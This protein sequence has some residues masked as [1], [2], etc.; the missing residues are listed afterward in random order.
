MV[1]KAMAANLK[2]DN[3]EAIAL[4]ENSKPSLNACIAACSLPC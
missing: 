2:A 1:A 4:I 3:S